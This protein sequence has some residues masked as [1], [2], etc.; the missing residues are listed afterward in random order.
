MDYVPRLSTRFFV[1]RL[2]RLR[3]APKA[4]FTLSAP[5]GTI[6][7]VFIALLV[8]MQQAD[9]NPGFAEICGSTTPAA[10]SE[11]TVAVGNRS[12][13]AIGANT[14][15]PHALNAGGRIIQNRYWTAAQ[16]LYFSAEH[17][18][19]SI[20]SLYCSRDMEVSTWSRNGIVFLR[21][22]EDGKGF[23]FL[24]NGEHKGG[25]LE[26]G[27][28]TGL[29]AQDG[30]RHGT[31]ARFYRLYRK[32]NLAATIAGYQLT[33]TDDDQ[34]TFGVQG[35]DIYAAYNG[36]E[37]VRFKDY[38]HI[39]DGFAAVQNNRF[40]GFRDITVR[41]LKPRALLSNYRKGEFD[42]RDFGMRSFQ[43]KGTMK[44][45]S[46]ILQLDRR[47]RFR[48]G[49][50][51]IISTGGEPGRGRRGTMGVGGSWP[52]TS[53]A[54]ATDL[55]SAPADILASYAWTVDTGQV[56]RRD[57]QEWVKIAN[58]YYIETAIPKALRARVIGLSEDGR[59]IRLDKV[60]RVETRSARVYYDNQ[61][62][63]NKIFR[64][65]R[66]DGESNF[67]V[68]SHAN[69][70]SAVTPSS[71]TWILPRGSFAIG[72]PII[73]RRHDGWTIRGA[74]KDRTKLFSPTGTPSAMVEITFA[75][76]TTVTALHVQ[77]NARDVGYMLLDDPKRFSDEKVQQGRAYPSGIV[78]GQESH[79]SRVSNVGVTDVFQKAVGAEFCNN[80]FA[81]RVQARM[82]DGLRKYVQWMF[83]WS[84][85]IGG[86]CIDCSVESP[87]LLAGFEA[88]ASKSV[89]FIRPIGVNAVVAMN[90]AGDFIIEDG[91]FIIEEGSQHEDRTF[92]EWNPIININANIGAN[93]F[94][95]LG[96][97]IVNT[98]MI[99]HGYINE[100]NDLLG[101]IVV[102]RH[103][104]NIIVEGGL[105]DAPGYAFPS[106]TP[107]A[108]GLRSTGTGLVV[109]GFQVYGS[110]QGRGLNRA[111]I[112][113][114]SG[115]ARNCLAE[116]IRT[117]NDGMVINCHSPAEANA[118]A[119]VRR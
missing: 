28:A 76:R 119:R 35:F 62:A 101:G 4:L 102:N 10:A 89:R 31:S 32:T 94:V 34:F 2:L 48:V 56:Y 106:K 30:Y 67:P 74:G 116:V 115:V 47:S 55:P 45:A 64:S 6:G 99:H 103:N 14:L 105:Y 88:F 39:G 107:G 118:G 49:D 53:F 91:L 1:V 92:S 73:L 15:S 3:L 41:H 9:A 77:G 59:S 75:P 96:G 29:F 100:R 95:S 113:F 110:V 37:I 27:I 18:S 23:F 19:F 97:R 90:S 8:S 66:Y 33:N 82:R 58:D 13:G 20:R 79:G 38:R 63:L 50:H 108:Q 80:C 69:D 21:V 93:E 114:S 72:G 42:M 26:I 12:V 109:D 24:H 43:A 16:T 84:D 104:P 86:G 87:F 68:A 46:P 40:Y 71:L 54:S 65:P 85:S 60:A 98:M 78:M 112:G 81:Y 117:T 70:L 36:V 57:E 22:N 52:H 17:T 25:T 51:V 5:G 11:Y 7:A 83:Q 61:P 111:N 44:A